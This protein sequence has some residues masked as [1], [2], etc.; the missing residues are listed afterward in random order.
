MQKLL[1]YVRGLKFEEDPDYEHMRKL[2]QRMYRR[3][4]LRND[5][6]F[7]WAGGLSH[8]IS[9]PVVPSTITGYGTSA[10]GK[11]SAISVQNK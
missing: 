5:G 10:A 4:G 9:R 1:T 3:N 8:G 2:I 6:E 7:D 11:Q